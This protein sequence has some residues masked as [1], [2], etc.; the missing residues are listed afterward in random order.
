MVDDRCLIGDNVIEVAPVT[1]ELIPR[2][3][4]PV[5]FRHLLVPGRKTGIVGA[6]GCDADEV[7]TVILELLGV[8]GVVHV[9]LEVDRL[10]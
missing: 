7:G 8:L 3:V 6:D 10:A 2:E 9:H 1:G 4:V 5:D